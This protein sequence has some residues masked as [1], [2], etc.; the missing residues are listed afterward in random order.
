M[1]AKAF[2]VIDCAQEM[3]AKLLRLARTGNLPDTQPTIMVLYFV[4][5]S[6]QIS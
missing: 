3:C 1:V 2:R 4:L 5:L 6:S